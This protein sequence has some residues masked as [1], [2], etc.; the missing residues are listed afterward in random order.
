MCAHHILTDF[1]SALPRGVGLLVALRRGSLTC[2]P[3]HDAARTCLASTERAAY[4]P[5]W[6]L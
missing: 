4:E 3:M 1:V 6:P 5:G 2:S